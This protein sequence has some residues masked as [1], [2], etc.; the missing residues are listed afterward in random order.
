MLTPLLREVPDCLV[1]SLDEVC[2]TTE[3][4]E[5]VPMA[6]TPEVPSE[7]RSADQSWSRRAAIMSV[8]ASATAIVATVVAAVKGLR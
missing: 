4:K 5:G 7:Q 6:E 1:Q 8:I 3:R 2:V